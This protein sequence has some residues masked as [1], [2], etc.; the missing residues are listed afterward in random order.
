MKQNILFES[1]P[2]FTGNSLEIYNE[3]L[4][5]G[6]DK[7]YNLIWAK[8]KQEPN[9]KDF[10]TCDLF[11]MN[12]SNILNN[13]QEVKDILNN[14]VLII[15]SNRLIQKPNPNVFRVHVRH[16]CCFKD[17]SKVY[18]SRVGDLD[19]ILTT[20]E[21]MK[22]IDEKFWAPCTKGKFI[23]T[24]LPSTDILFRP[25]N[26]YNGFIQKLTGNN[27]KFEKI[28][29]WLPTFRTGKDGKTCGRKFK[30]GVPTIYN[31]EQ[32]SK[33]ND[34]LKQNN[35]LILISIHHY[36]LKDYEQPK[37]SNIYYVTD[38]LK[39]EFNLT[40][41]NLMSS[42]DALIT[43]Y[44]AAYHEYIIL[45]RPIGLT[46]DDLIEYSKTEGFCYKYDEWIKGEYILD[47]KD[48]IKFISNVKDNID[49][50]KTEREKSLHKIHKY[51]DNKSAERVVNYLINRVKL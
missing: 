44:S 28:I 14:T 48:L 25:Q 47:V 30:Y 15:D 11:Y 4:K 13:T 20:S 50:S 23:V 40:S 24:G 35:I 37:F 29:G 19:A 5:R 1:I 10:K 27:N 36:Q 9:N 26:L 21:E 43:D 16:G 7:K 18:Y 8:S 3:F 17:C 38:E 32:F 41:H 46:V 22:I 45:N 6:L 2:C 33:L 51:I 31:Y 34:Y 49:L 39:N 42:F 12:N